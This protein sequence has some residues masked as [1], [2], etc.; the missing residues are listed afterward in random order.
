M[1]PGWCSFLRRK[2][3]D[4]DEFWLD[5]GCCRCGKLQGYVARKA[6][7]QY[8]NPNNNQTGGNAYQHCV[9]SCRTKKR[10]RPSWCARLFWTAHELG[11]DP[12][13]EMDLR[14][15]EA[16]YSCGDSIS[17]YEGGKCLDCCEKK[18]RDGQL[19]CLSEKQDRFIPCPP[20]GPRVR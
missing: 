10:C 15:N 17:G 3:E 20:P 5:H 19:T 16:G 9:A 11:T 14:N 12:E 4:Y 18:W 8:G 1:D 13:S 2:Y 6:A 7:E